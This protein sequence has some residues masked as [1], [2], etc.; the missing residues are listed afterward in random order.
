MEAREPETARHEA[1]DAFYIGDTFHHLAENLRQVFWIADLS[2]EKVY[3]ISPSYETIWGRSRASLYADPVSWTASIH[4]EDMN[5]VRRVLTARKTDPYQ[6]EYRILHPQGEVRWI[7]DRGFPVRDENGTT[8]RYAGIAEDI[9]DRKRAETALRDSE[10]KYRHLFEM[11]SDANFLFDAKTGRI[12]EANHVA[13][14]LYGYSRLELLGMNRAELCCKMDRQD[15]GT[16]DN[17]PKS[18]VR[19]H[20]K[21]DGTVFPAEVTSRSFSLQG[22]KVRIAAVRDVTE[23]QRFDEELERR[24]SFFRRIIDSDPTLI[25]VKD[26]EG[27]IVLANRSLADFFGIPMKDLIGKT[28]LDCMQDREAAKEMQRDD[29]EILYG[30]IDRVERELHFKNNAGHDQWIYMIKLPMKNNE[31]AIDQLIG[32]CIVLT[33]Y[34]MMR[35]AIARRE[36]ELSANRRELEMTNTALEVLLKRMEREKD[37]LVENILV[38]MNERV[39]PYLQKL[40]SSRL[41]EVQ[42]ACLDILKAALAEIGSPFTRNLPRKHADLST[43]EVRVASLVKAGRENKEI[44]QILGVSLNT[45]MTHRYHLRAKLGVKGKKINLRSYLNSIQ[46]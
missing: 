34:K 44:A 5:R 29:R 39:L 23:R 28:I 42:K 21:S 17:L 31:G 15:G 22:R 45:I 25:Y 33:E 26:R 6:V 46:F 24:Q 40:E 16:F 37:N 7:L 12:L 18:P 38:N 20:Q 2:G 4:P 11:E 43:M 41:D 10:Q 32:V 14:V 35:R 8:C 36:K 1:L 19:Y 13:S 27:R 3:Y 30:K 9:S